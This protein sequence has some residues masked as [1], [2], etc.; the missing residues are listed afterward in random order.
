MLSKFK[1]LKI[2]N[3]LTICSCLL[4]LILAIIYPICYAKTAEMSWMLLVIIILMAICSIVAIV[5]NKYTISQNILFIFSLLAIILFF[6][7]TFNYMVDAFVGID[8]TN[9]S[10][11]FTLILIFLVLEFIINLIAN[12]LETK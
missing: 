10:T 7:S 12:I 2:G 9:L 4:A 8:V 5:T 6:S 11:Q 1:N 3:Y